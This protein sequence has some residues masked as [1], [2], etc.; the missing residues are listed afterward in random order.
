MGKGN[1]LF[2]QV[3][4][5][6]PWAAFD[7]A[8][9][10]LRG[11]HK[12]QRATCRSHVLVLLLAMLRG[13]HSLRRIEQGLSGRQRYLSIFGIGSVDR[14]TVSL[15]NRHRPAEVADA[16]FCALLQR[17]QTT[18]PR[19]GFPFRQKVF[20]LD[21]T[22]IQ[23][24]T[25]LYP[26]ARCAEDEAG[27]KLHIFLDHDGL[28]PC[29]V[30]FGTLKTSEL[31][32]A[33]Q[34][35]YDAGTVLCFDQGYFDTAWF[36]RLTESGVTFVTRL[37]PN[38]HYTVLRERAR[39]AGSNVLADEIIRFTSA[40]CRRQYPQPLRLITFCDPATGNLLW[41]LTNQLSWSAETVAA[42][43]KSRWQ[44]ELF[45]K[46]LK[47][48]LKLSHLLGRNANAVRWQA[49]LALCLYLMLAT[50]GFDYGT[51]PGGLLD[52]LNQYLFDKTTL[53]ELL[54]FSYQ[55]QT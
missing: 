50:W 40:T 16:L 23:V 41:F 35:S 3:Q 42:V 47:Q 48:H 22:V 13:Q 27:I 15:A 30:E 49:L 18:A 12:V 29:L 53:Q 10:R 37:P 11:D 31:K 43:Y 21:A 28:L 4:A 9:L 44:I 24:S 8:V 2:A 5:R 1:T 54:T 55:F 26:W 20:T 25:V 36:R 51:S 6:L 34:R 19:H 17:A 52:Q 46:W 33:R 14:S 32:L 45:F 38:P 39:A 7:R